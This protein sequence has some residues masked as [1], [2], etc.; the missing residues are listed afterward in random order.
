MT[1]TPSHRT[2]LAIPSE[3]PG[4]LEAARSEHFGRSGCF[5]IAEFN[6]G[7]VVSIEV[8]ENPPHRHGG[9]MSPVIRLTEHNVDAIAVSGIGGGPLRGFHQVGIAVYAGAGDDV[10]GCVEA[11]A[12]NE[13]PPFSAEHVCR[14]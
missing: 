5:T 2:R 4:G 13:L 6:D 3:N 10:K 14:H 9:C 11:F 7:E 1:S 8:L 12:R